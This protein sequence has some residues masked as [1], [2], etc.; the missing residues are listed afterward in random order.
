[1]ISLVV[2]VSKNGVIG[3][4][5]ELLW[6]LSDDL[7]SFKKITSN[8]DIIMG[9]KT[10][11]SIGKALPN[12]V[13]I[14]VSSTMSQEENMDVIVAKNPREAL[15]KSYRNGDVYIIGGAN[16]Y[17]QMHMYCDTIYLTLVDCEI[18]GD[19]HFDLSILKDFNEIDRKKFEKSDKNEFNFDIIK[20]IRK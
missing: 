17:D 20:Y 2:A 18:D 15:L 7:K 6:H 12:R 11:E 3:G 16:I 5:N 14:V 8:S 13:N 4:D 1:M 19:A 9:R 10:Y